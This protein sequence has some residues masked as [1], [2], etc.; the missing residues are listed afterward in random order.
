MT[1]SDKCLD[2]NYP[3]TWEHQR[4]QF[5]RLMRLGMS[6]QDAKSI[7]PRCQKCMTLLL[8]DRRGVVRVTQGDAPRIIH[9]MR[10]HA[11][12]VDK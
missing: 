7:L 3:M 11:R 12:S 5:G 8:R 2:C 9:R 1:A 6:V 4:R 10:A